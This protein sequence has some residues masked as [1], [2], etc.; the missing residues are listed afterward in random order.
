[1]SVQTPQGPIETIGSFSTIDMKKVTSPGT[2][3]VDIVMDLKKILSVIVQVL[4]SGN[5]VVTS[6][7]DITF[8]GNTVTVAD[9]SSFSLADTYIIHVLARG[10]NI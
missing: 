8:S 5:N 4:D 7:A 10:E 9:G 6:D 2:T 3:S 1:M